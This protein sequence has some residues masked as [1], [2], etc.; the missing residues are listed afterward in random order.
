MNIEQGYQA[1]AGDERCF[2]VT[3]MY[4]I[5][6]ITNL[7]HMHSTVVCLLHLSKY[8]VK[9]TTQSVKTSLTIR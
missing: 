3:H 2:T 1:N 4:C 5:H 8:C 7:L 9:V 6:T